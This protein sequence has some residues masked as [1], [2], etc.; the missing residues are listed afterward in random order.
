MSMF[1]LFLYTSVLASLNT[2]CIGFNTI[3]KTFPN[4]VYN[5]IVQQVEEMS[6]NEVLWEGEMENTVDHYLN[7]SVFAQRCPDG[8]LSYNFSMSKQPCGGWIVKT[9]ID[10]IGDSEKEIVWQVITPD[11]GCINYLNNVLVYT[12]S[13]D[14]LFHAPP[15]IIFSEKLERCSR[16]VVFNSTPTR[17]EFSLIGADEW[18]VNSDGV[19]MHS[20]DV[21]DKLNTETGEYSI[22]GIIQVTERRYTPQGVH[23]SQES[24]EPISEQYPNLR[25]IIS[26]IERSAPKERT[27]SLHH[28]S[29][30]VHAATTTSPIWIS[31]RFPIE[32]L[33]KKWVSEN[34]MHLRYIQSYTARRLLEQL[35]Q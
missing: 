8:G 11:S 17:Y 23:T 9:E 35:K 19:V 12:K 2:G 32:E 28:V 3:S 31:G 22:P 26:S 33:M 24:Y 30:L 14:F 13:G 4:E 34:D 29:P 27:E 6:A 7:T 5:L 15:Q 25:K 1:H 18:L 21:R 10:L 20:Y 16:G